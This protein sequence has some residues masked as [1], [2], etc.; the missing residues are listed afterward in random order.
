MIY[1]GQFGLAQ[2]GEAWIGAFMGTISAGAGL[3]GFINSSA[4]AVVVLPNYFKGLATYH[5]IG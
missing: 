4:L 1:T 2:L 3:S 5:R